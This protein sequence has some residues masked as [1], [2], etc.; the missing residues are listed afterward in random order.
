MAKRSTGYR[1]RKRKSCTVCYHYI[2][3]TKLNRLGINR[4]CP[5]HIYGVNVLNSCKI[6]MHFML[7]INQSCATNK[8]PSSGFGNVYDAVDT[9]FVFV[10]Q[11]WNKLSAAHR[12]IRFFPWINRYSTHT[13][14]KNHRRMNCAEASSSQSTKPEIENEATPSISA[15]NLYIE[16][17]CVVWIG[18]T[19][20]EWSVNK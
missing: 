1:E 13:H 11:L 6:T 19:S 10:V 16:S 15:C 18:C 7:S 4:L 17:Y 14:T 2:C 8:W 5:Y 20:L 12:T 9:R 3:C